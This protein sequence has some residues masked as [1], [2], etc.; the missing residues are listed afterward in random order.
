[1]STH[2]HFD[3][4]CVA[5]LIL[6]LAVTILFMNGESLGITVVPDQDRESYTGSEYFTQN[7]LD[8]EWSGKVTTRI[9][10]NG[11]SAK[12][13]GSG[14]YADSGSVTIVQ[15]GYYIVSG[16]LDDGSLIVDAKNYSKVWI[17]LD[18][19]TI[20]SSGSAC[21]DVEQAD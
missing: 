18:G 1:M 21:I 5:V 3:K 12:V 20:T 7:D 19:V 10:L 6:T 17:L 11:S 14:A 9:S 4:I 13:S 16:T 8:A 15:S 2:R